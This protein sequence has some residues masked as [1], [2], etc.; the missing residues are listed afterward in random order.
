MLHANNAI[1]G[2]SD[3]E[4]ILLKVGI[5]QSKTPRFRQ[6]APHFPDLQMEQP[7][8]YDFVAN[9]DVYPDYNEMPYTVEFAEG[10]EHPDWLKIEDNKL[11]AVEVPYVKWRFE[12]VYLTVRNTLG[13]ISPAEYFKLFITD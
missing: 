2:D 13:G 8:L 6:D 7:Y 5:N 4:T 12:R 9:H 10:Y 11:I 3:P 1:G